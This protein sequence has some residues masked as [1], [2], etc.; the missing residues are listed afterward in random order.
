M[1][2][3]L[4]ALVLGAPAVGRADSVTVNLIGTNSDAYTLALQGQQPVTGHTGAYTWQQ[5]GNNGSLPSTFQT[6]CVE[7]LQSTHSPTTYTIVPLSQVPDP[8]TGVPGG[9]GMGTT[10]ATLISQLWGTFFNQTLGNADN[11]AAFQL[12]IWEFVYGGPSD[13]WNLTDSNAN[14]FVVGGT[15]SGSVVPLAQTWVNDIVHQLVPITTET[16]LVGLTNS[17]YQDQITTVP[18]PPSVWMACVGA[19]GLVA[20]AWRRR[21][22]HAMA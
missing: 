19:L 18:A 7:L 22:A 20:G 11:Q 5:V 15:D 4:L 16:D 8:G 2:A 10:R 17:Q 1:V 12:A 6:Y 13:N 9:P 3:G 21:W 14:F